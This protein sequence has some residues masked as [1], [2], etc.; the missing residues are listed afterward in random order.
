MRW[1]N[2]IEL[3]DFWIF[4]INTP[5]ELGQGRATDHSWLSGCYVELGAV[6]LLDKTSQFSYGYQYL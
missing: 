5:Y 4:D 3:G 2:S 1:P 6:N